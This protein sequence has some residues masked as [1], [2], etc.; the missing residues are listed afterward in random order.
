MIVLW[1]VRT[2]IHFEWQAIYGAAH[3]RQFPDG[4]AVTSDDFSGGEQ[5]VKNPLEALGFEFL[6]DDGSGDSDSLNLQ[7]TYG[8]ILE[9]ARDRC[10]VSYSDLAKANGAE[11]KKSSGGFLITRRSR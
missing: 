1:T 7:T 3:R 2:L 10:F 4:G 9:A 6:A 8:A 11:W 5:A